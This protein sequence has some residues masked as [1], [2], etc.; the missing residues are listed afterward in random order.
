MFARVFHLFVCALRAGPL[1]VPGWALVRRETRV[2]ASADSSTTSA[3][4]SPS[5]VAEPHQEKLVCVYGFASGMRIY[6]YAHANPVNNVDPSGHDG[7]QSRCDPHH[8][9]PKPS[10]QKRPDAGAEGAQTIVQ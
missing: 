1:S 10:C 6:L 8:S 2:G 4:E 5:Q 7:E 3:Q 9:F